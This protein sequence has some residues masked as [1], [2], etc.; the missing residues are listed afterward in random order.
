MHPFCLA[1]LAFTLSS[2]Q[3]KN[4]RNF[5]IFSLD[6]FFR[7]VYIEFR[8]PEFEQNPS[9]PARI[10][11]RKPN[12]RACLFSKRDKIPAAAPSPVSGEYAPANTNSRQLNTPHPKVHLSSRRAI[13][14]GSPKQKCL[15]GG[16][17]RLRGTEKPRSVPV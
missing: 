15:Q 11:G 16:K 7:Q 10:Y 17:G 6:K 14:G 3:R 12:R 1:P 9:S 5:L 4:I 2:Y 13:S 8:K